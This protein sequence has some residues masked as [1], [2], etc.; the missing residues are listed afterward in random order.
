VGAC[1]SIGARHVTSGWFGGIST[2][3]A[4]VSKIVTIASPTTL[5]RVAVRAVGELPRLSRRPCAMRCLATP[6]DGMRA[7]SPRVHRRGEPA[8][9]NE[10]RGAHAARGDRGTQR[11]RQAA[12]AR[13]IPTAK[14]PAEKGAGMGRRC[15]RATPVNLASRRCRTGTRGRAR[16]GANPAGVRRVETFGRGQFMEVPVRRRWR[17]KD[18]VNGRHIFPQ[19]SDGGHR[20]CLS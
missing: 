19:P 11:A 20:L 2:S 7:G 5:C 17:Q 1:R 8:G 4:G 15:L 12:E 13:W 10:R 3:T 14:T 18:N 9:A 16:R 6:G